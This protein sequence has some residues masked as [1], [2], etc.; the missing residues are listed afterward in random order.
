V[1]QAIDD[2]LDRMAAL[3]EADRRNG[4][5]RRQLL[6]ALGDIELV[7]QRTRRFAPI[8]VVRA[9]ARVPSRSIA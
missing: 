8:A 3:D 9:Y 7:V 5:Y 2:H 4:C 1:T 6:T